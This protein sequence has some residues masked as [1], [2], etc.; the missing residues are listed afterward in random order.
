MT[1]TQNCLKLMSLIDATCLDDHATEETII[2]LCH[3][4]KRSPARVASICVYPKWIALVKDFFKN[5]PMTITTVVNYP[6]PTLASQTLQKQIK[7]ATEIGADEVDIVFPY[8]TFDPANPLPTLEFLKS[9]KKACKDNI[10]KVIIESGEAPSADWIE[11]ATECVIESGANFVK[12]STGKTATGATTEAVR[13]IAYTLHEG[14]R[15]CGLK[16][17]GGIRTIEQ[18]NDYIKLV[19]SILSPSFITP[20][21]FRFGASS[22]LTSC[23][24]TIEN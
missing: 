19:E 5:R 24:E 3:L 12:T 11:K 13:V 23:I 15:P 16:I 4:A 18:A 22:L 8:D 7:L 20:E 17:S 6:K 14:D 2:N 1:S 21:W 9:A 10:L